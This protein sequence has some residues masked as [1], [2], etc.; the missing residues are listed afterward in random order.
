MNSSSINSYP[1]SAADGATEHVERPNTDL[2][3]IRQVSTA[4]TFPL[5]RFPLKLL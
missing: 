5:H 1:I 3:C 4:T 2:L